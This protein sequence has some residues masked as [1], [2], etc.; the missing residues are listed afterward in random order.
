MLRKIISCFALYRFIGCCVTAVALILDLRSRKISAD[1][2]FMRVVAGH[3]GNGRHDVTGR[4]H[5]AR[6]VRRTDTSVWVMRR[7]V[8][9]A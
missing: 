4:N 3:V 2:S 5:S 8:R 7:S 1:V 9:G 6:P